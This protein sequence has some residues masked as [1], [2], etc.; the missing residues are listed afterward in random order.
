MGEG[1]EN[2]V[3]PTI[4]EVSDLT[5]ID[6]AASATTALVM[7][8]GEPTKVGEERILGEKLGPGTFTSTV[9]L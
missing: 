1:K 2:E 4:E 9:D 8:I 7:D 3:Q 5:T 6:A